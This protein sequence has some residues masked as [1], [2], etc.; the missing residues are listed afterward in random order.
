MGSEYQ[1]IVNALCHDDLSLLE[2]PIMLC[3]G[4]I[5][6]I[7][8]VRDGHVDAMSYIYDVTAREPIG[9]PR[10]WRNTTPHRN[11]DDNSEMSWLS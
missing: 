9:D 8:S 6:N 1:R 7:P 4:P 2:H 5:R 10:R 11:Y 3:G